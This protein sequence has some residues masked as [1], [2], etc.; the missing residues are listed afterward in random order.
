MSLA[1]PLLMWYSLPVSYKQQGGHVVTL[2][3]DFLLVKRVVSK[4]LCN[5]ETND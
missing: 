4:G 1:K 3:P 5:G 2:N